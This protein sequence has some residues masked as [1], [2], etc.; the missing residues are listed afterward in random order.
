MGNELEL[1]NF[2]IVRIRLGN[3]MELYNFNI[4]R[5]RLG[6]ELELY[7]FNIAGK[8]WVMSWNFM[9]LLVSAFNFS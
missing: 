4:V 5:I 8:D 7:N 1:Y 9:S 6:N 3:K 2:N